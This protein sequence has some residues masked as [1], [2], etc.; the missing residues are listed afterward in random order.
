MLT[1]TNNISEV[2]SSLVCWCIRQYN[3]YVIFPCDLKF[4]VCGCVCDIVSGCVTLSALH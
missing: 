4:C 3:K 1:F 2:I